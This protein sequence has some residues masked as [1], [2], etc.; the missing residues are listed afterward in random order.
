MNEGGQS[1]TGQLVEHIITTHPAYSELLLLAKKSGKDN[2]A[3]LEELLETLRVTNNADTLTDVIKDLHLYPDF[4]GNRSP[5]ADPRMRGSIVGLDL[6]SSISDLSRRYYATLEAIA[7]QTQHIIEELNSKGHKITAIY[8]SGG[9]AKNM[10]LMQ[11]FAD[12]C[13][14]PVVLPGGD[15]DAVVLGAAMLG[16][17]AAEGQEVT[18]QAELLWKIM[19]EMSPVGTRINPKASL[20]EMRLLRAKY[21]IYRESA[22]I[23]KRWRREM[24]DASGPM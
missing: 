4:H 5:I 3:V 7:L 1:C 14:M 22:E 19:A 11:L 17:F 10:L 13:Q 23:Q 12:V 6:D 21:K 18:R 9:Q 20:K 2:H 8:A 16:R 24:E 15:S